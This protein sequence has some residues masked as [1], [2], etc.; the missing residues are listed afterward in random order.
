MGDR[1]QKHLLLATGREASGSLGVHP[2]LFI[3]Y[4]LSVSA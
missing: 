1:Y 2:L 3:E 4:L